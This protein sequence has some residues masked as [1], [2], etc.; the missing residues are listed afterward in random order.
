[1]KVGLIAA[2]VGGVV[3]I[4][5]TMIYGLP[6]LYPAKYD[7]YLDPFKDPQDRFTMARVIIQNTGNAPLTNVIIDYD[8]YIDKISVLKPG[9][10]LILSPPTENKLEKVTVTTDEG[11]N[12]TMPYRLPIKMPGMMGS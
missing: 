6:I 12:M 11:I 1:M 10:K 9:Q 2:G 4:T 3:I 5:A 8:G 7:L